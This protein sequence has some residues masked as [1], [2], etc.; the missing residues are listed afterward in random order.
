MPTFRSAYDPPLRVTLDCLDVS[1]TKQSMSEECNINF[2]MRKYQKT[3]AIEHLKTHQGRYD[4]FE[5]IEFHEAMNIVT[6]AQ[7]MFADLPSSIRSKFQNDP[8]TFLAFANDPDNAEAMVELG[9]ANPAAPPP[10][11]PAPAPEPAPPPPET[12]E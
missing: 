7:S 5:P 8:G 6:T 12:P 1:L 11:P 3:G 2:I 9:L 10:P 4:E